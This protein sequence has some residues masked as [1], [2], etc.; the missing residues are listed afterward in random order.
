MSAGCSTRTPQTSGA[1]LA[2]SGLAWTVERHPVEAVI[3][4]RDGGVRREPAQRFVAN[5]RGDTDAVVGIVGDTYSPLQNHESFELAD[6]IVDSGEAHWVGAGSTRGGAHIHAVMR[7]DREVCIGGATGEDVLPLLFLRSGHD[8]R[9][10]LTVSV[11]P[12]RLACLNGMIIPVEG[13]LRSWRVR[14]TARMRWQIGGARKALRVA[15]GYYDKLEELGS[16]LLAEPMRA[17][18]FDC[19]T[20]LLVPNGDSPA[21]VTRAQRVW[22]A[23]RVTYETTPDLAAIRGT[24]WGAFQAVA[25]YHDHHATIRATPTRSLGEARFKR[26]TTPSALKDRALELLAA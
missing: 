14:H 1:V 8:G 3:A 22:D 24:R 12:F 7:L 21:A 4:R 18:E 20:R 2:A 19:F 16:L 10:S 5:V 25:A 17:S 13:E 6:T 15:F 9:L 26:A 23:V 11:A